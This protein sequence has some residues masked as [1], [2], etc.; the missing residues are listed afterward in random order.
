MLVQ[1]LVALVMKLDD[2]LIPDCVIN[3][4]VADLERLSPLQ[5]RLLAAT[6]PS[7][8]HGF[9]PETIDLKV[10]RRRLRAVLEKSS[11]LPADLRA[12]LR[13]S[14]LSTSLLSV[15]SE[16]ALA[17]LASPLGDFFGTEAIVAALLLDDRRSVRDLAR[18]LLGKRNA[19]TPGVI[20]TEAASLLITELSP[21]L[22]QMGALLVHHQTYVAN[23]DDAVG[24]TSTDP[25]TTIGLASPLAAR[26]PRPKREADLVIALRSLRQEANRLARENNS[27]TSQLKAANA[28]GLT[29]EI[30][31][32]ATRD[33]LRG[34]QGELG[35]LKSQFATRV[36][37][38]LSDC[39]D[40]RLVP[41]LKPAE[42]L[43]RTAHALRI[44]DQHDVAGTS[45]SESLVEHEAVQLAQRILARQ[46][47]ADRK[48]GIISALHAERDRCNVLRDRLL[49]A[50]IESIR[51]LAEL[52][53][54]IQAL[55]LRIGQI[56]AALKA[57]S[58][59]QLGI[60]SS[61]MKLNESIARAD[62][63]EK[64]STLRQHLIA[65]EPLGIL[66][67]E[68]L[69][70]AFRM[71]D[72]ASSKVYTSV[73]VQRSWALGRDDINGLPYYAIR[74]NLGTGKP[75]ALIVDG[76]NVLWKVP[77]LFRSHYENDQPGTHA[78]RVLENALLALA[79]R[80]TRLS[81]H[82]WFD[83][84]IIEDRTLA[85]N[86]RV[87]FSGGQ[88]TGRADRQIIAY[89][90][91]L[92]ASGQDETRAVV[93]ADNEIANSARISNA[94]VMTPQELGMWLS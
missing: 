86:L 16:E 32:S 64:L 43:A 7:I 14:G 9:R 79:T 27:L 65:S 1:V 81:I 80:Y 35:E 49:E 77:S 70:H 34:A 88:G 62:S 47:E 87:H 58:E 20:R 37:E 18:G 94:L 50:Q 23:L 2:E 30:T 68:E 60:S 6:R 54:G 85:P 69:E 78:R 24:Q 51:P 82:L 73:G 67:E 17:R 31:L 8:T 42:A 72:Q 33:Q 66:N 53:V 41:W 63:L 38:A 71:L 3:S 40:L 93:T 10:A 76:H 11:E 26:G 55:E 19:S 21:F 45:P 90:T 44:S 56:E 61:L 83:S 15:F 57:D 74:V 36:E 25:R 28:R 13:V 89:L 29:N 92:N 46:A 52:T 5:I 91:H 84:N 59:A 48:F 12:Q 39:M 4:W 22:A 75:C